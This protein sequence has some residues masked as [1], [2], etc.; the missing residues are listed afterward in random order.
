MSLRSSKLLF[1]LPRLI[2][3]VRRNAES[4]LNRW[5][6]HTDSAFPKTFRTGPCAS[7]PS[8]LSAKPLLDPI[9][10][11]GKGNVHPGCDTPNV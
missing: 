5:L 1:L 6:S 9:T 10:P 7:K 4:Q 8:T 11:L 2:K 3:S